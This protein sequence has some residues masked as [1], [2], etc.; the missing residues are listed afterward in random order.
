MKMMFSFLALSQ[1]TT[2]LIVKQL[3]DDFIL[4]VSASLLLGC[5]LMF[6]TALADR[7]FMVYVAPLVER[8]LKGGR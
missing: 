5:L 7:V 3:S 4:A 2:F 1:I 6:F 8:L